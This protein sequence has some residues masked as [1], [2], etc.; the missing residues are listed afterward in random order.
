MVISLPQR[1]PE[2]APGDFYVKAGCCMRCCLP[3]GEAPNLLND[4]KQPFEEC[5]FRCQPQTPDE[6]DQAINAIWVSEVCALRYGGTNPAIISKLR[7]K[8]LAA[9]CDHTPEGQA[10][11]NHVPTSAAPQKVSWWRELFRIRK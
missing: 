8:G 9:Q 2:N 7:A 3:H 1:V 4:P 5:F 11:I 6:I 10:W